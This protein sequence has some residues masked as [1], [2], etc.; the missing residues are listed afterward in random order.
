MSRFQYQT[1]PFSLLFITMHMSLTTDY[2]TLFIYIKRDKRLILCITFKQNSPTRIYNSKS[3]IKYIIELG[4]SPIN[5]CL[6]KVRGWKKDLELIRENI[7]TPCLI[8]YR[9]VKITCPRYRG[10]V[11]G[12]L[13]PGARRRNPAA[14]APPTEFD[15]KDFAARCKFKVSGA[16]KLTKIR[17]IKKLETN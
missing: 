6:A 7:P 17:E 14:Q 1:P 16:V 2:G 11:S 12:A 10:C 15:N 4:N 3:S 13:T 9:Q 8:K 5:R